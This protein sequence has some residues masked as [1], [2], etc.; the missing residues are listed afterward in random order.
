MLAE[1]T[2]VK[3][4]MA[5]EHA[6]EWKAAMD[7][8]IQ[9][10][11]KFGCFNRV[12]ASQASTGRLVKNKWVF[13]VKYNA[14]GSLQ[15][16]KARLVAKGF[17]QIPG[18]D[19]YDTF[20][21]VFSY[22]SLRVLLAKAAAEDL[23][24]DQWDLKNGF[25]QQDIDVEH[26]YMKCP[27]G[28]SD[29]MPDGSKAALHCLKSI[30]GLKQSSR[31]LHNRLSR[32]LK[33]LGYRQ[34]ASDQCVY[35]KGTGSE[36]MIVCTWVDDIIVATSRENQVGREK[37]DLDL[38]AEFEVSPWTCGE[39]G[40]ILNMK[41]E[42]DWENSTLHLSQEMAIEKLAVKFGLT[43][44][45]CHIP[46]QSNL[47]LSKTPVD[48]RVDVAV[49]DYMSA[50]GGLLYLSLTAR[51]DVAYAV[52]VLSRYM[53]CPGDDHVEAAKRVIRYLYR[54]K[55]YGIRYSKGTHDA[56][57]MAPHVL[58][59]PVVYVKKYGDEDSGV[60]PDPEI[61]HA[62]SDGE[63]AT[64]EGSS[65]PR[66]TLTFV[67]CPTYVDADLAGDLDT[68]RSTT[69]FAIMLFGGIVCWMAKLQSTVALSTSEAETNAATEAVKQL[70]HMRLFLREL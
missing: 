68:M 42:R 3:D 53:A 25:I 10:L 47:K 59:S 39:A 12:P 17:T 32:Y 50:V 41:I 57:A 63:E 49:F 14:D 36:Q 29:L 65:G 18:S 67:E 34:L 8:E 16:F 21:P 30:Y 6:I 24:I 31:L 35:I 1:P 4:A 15:R 33:D 9:N 5:S 48:D 58:D 69:G 64:A 40:W 56:A 45:G 38:R 2:S 7:E 11:I 52:G 62:K 22:T 46:M 61:M 23:Q 66:E 13:K 70:M 55:T 26:M 37:F 28:Y 51:P 43:D 19:F 44:Y 54:T 20:S 60:V 27:E